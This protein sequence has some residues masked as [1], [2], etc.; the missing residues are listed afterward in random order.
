MALTVNTNLAGLNAQRNLG[1]NNSQM[2]KSLE[3]LSSGLRINRAADDAAGLAIAT[4]FGAQVRGLNQ[5]VRNANNAISLLQTA[6]GGL[7]TITNILQRLRE[8]SVQSASEDNTASDRTNLATESDELVAELT[9]L[10]NTSE[11]NTMALLD[12]TFSSK[13]FQIGANF[14]Q[15]VSISIN[16]ARGKS[17]GGRAQYDADIADGVANATDANFGASEFKVNSKSIVA[18]DSADDQ[19][20]VLE[21]S[22]STVSTASTAGSR[23]NMIINNTI[24]S[25]DGLSTDLTSN[26]D[27]ITSAINGA[28]IT[29]VSAILMSDSWVLRAKAGVDIELGAS[30]VGGGTFAS[31]LTII[32]LSAVSAML[33]SLATTASAS[34]ADI[35]NY[36]GQSSAIAK[37]TA[38]NEIKS[39]SN[40]SGD[41]RANIITAS[42]AITAGTISAGDVYINGIDIGAV[43]VT[44]SDSTGALVTAI[45]NVSSSTGVTASTDSNNKLVLTA[46]DGRNITVSTEASGDF[47]TLGID[48]TNYVTNRTAIF[49]SS[50]R[51]TDDESFSLTGT[52]GD[53]YDAGT[54]A[55]NNNTK[56]TDS[57]KNITSD[58]S[59]Y[60]IASIDITTKSNAEAAILTID[61]AL[62]DVNATRANIGAVQNRVEFTV[63]NL[64]IASE[65]MSASESRIRDA[66]FAFEVSQFTK[67]QILVQAGTAMLAQANTLPQMALQLLQ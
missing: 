53:L 64:E 20:S 14:S 30:A 8:L 52:L 5:A 49:R 3:R 40:V 18:T 16:D 45:N 2:S 24:V 57:T 50:V 43:T 36:N 60:N 66:D 17:M 55:A 54:T 23:I 56:T 67:N 46:S 11:Y 12:G 19:F 35:I 4:K 62:D 10:A 48:T 27:I 28:G 47:T 22:S 42:T 63:A 7:N 1:I 59:T 26:A 29:N 44:A 51:M 34:T 15:T 38:I 39:D 25:F 65:N 21:I 41:A 32:G 61:A 37:A 58:V 31:T 9:R 6:E 33:G 13:V